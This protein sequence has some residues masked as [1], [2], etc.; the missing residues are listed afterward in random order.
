MPDVDAPPSDSAGA[1]DAEKAQERVGH[2]LNA[3][4][5]L[6]SLLGVGGMGAVYTARHRN[7]SRAAVK[8]L[9]AEYARDP[10]VRDRFLR[11]GKIA[12]RVDHPARVPVTDDDVSD[13]GEPF[14]V[15]D[16]LEGLTLGQMR[17]RNDGKVA[18][19][20]VL[21][22]F[23]TVLDLLGKCH[24]LGIVH[25]DI[26]PANIFVT[27]NGDI[28]VLDF[29]VARMHDPGSGVEATR[30]GTAIGTPSYMA[31]EQ[32][33]G[34]GSQ[35]DGRSDVWSVG[36]C[37]YASL[38]GQ[39]LNVAR[40]EAESFV[41]A[42]TQAAPS[43]ANLAPDLPVEVVAFVDRA[44]AFERG[45]RF[46]DAPSMR[47]DLLGLLS[48]LRA[49]QLVATA[50]KKA[51]GVR[52]R[53]NETIDT[54]EE[55]SDK[56]K[57]AVH[58]KLS[59][60]WKQLGVCLADVR[61]YG[62]THPQSRR[63]MQVGY[64][65]VAEML[66]AYP[67]SLRWDVGPGAF[68][69][70]GK[71]VWAPD[72]MPFDRIPYQLFGDGVRHIQIKEGLTEDELHD[73][74]AI[75]LRDLGDGVAAA[76]TE[77]DSVTALW[78]RRFEHVAY[79]AID[80]FA[81]GTGDS[82]QTQAFKRQVD[83]LAGS[84]AALAQLDRDMD[85][86]SLEERA[87][88]KNLVAQLRESG[89]AAATLAL[90]PLTK[91][92][93]GAQL[94]LSEDKWRERF[95]D[96]FVEAYV[97]ARA[98][99]D[100]ALL[101]APLREWTTDQ[102]AL[103]GHRAIFEMFE[104]LADKLAQRE[105]TARSAIARVM[106]PGPHIAAILRD[107]EKEGRD[108]TRAAKEIEPSIVQG[109]SK[110]LELLGDGSMLGVACGC[111]DSFRSEAL[112]DVL[113]AYIRRW[114]MGNEKELAGVI[115]SAG[116]DLGLLLVKLLG[117][118]STPEA[119]EALDRA[120]ANPH[121]QVRIEALAR[122][123]ADK[124]EHVRSEIEKMLANP[125]A[126]VRTEALKLIAAR[127]LRAAGPALVFRAQAPTFHDMPAEERRQWL[128]A[129]VSLNPR[130]GEALCAGLLAHHT[131]IQKESVEVT[132]ALAA[133]ILTAMSSDEALAAAQEGAKKRWWNSQAVREAS[134]RALKAIT[135]RRA[136]AAP[137]GDP[138]P[139]KRKAD[140]P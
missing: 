28:K 56:E 117:E 104:A 138:P 124:E 119:A 4:W 132:R 68:L 130:R 5:T 133:E 23:D 75:F 39:R 26:K 89:E 55:L 24:A 11:E 32:A 27:K 72:R 90:D 34:L 63:T 36:A 118:I 45:K 65:Q 106:L 10:Q 59:G 79:L 128:K 123:P 6:E 86:V 131:L 121:L 33:L 110:A 87:M 54:G 62:W 93:L 30:A 85:D 46:Q 96:G 100:L 38:T 21:R 140:T 2:A 88:Q 40:T 14:L 43:I 78:D 73:L 115:Q 125:A 91:A 47:S 13:S 18:L 49:G 116:V 58:E 48:A 113:L 61:Q 137:G 53:G 98:R 31:P 25:R 60:V 129:I 126:S 20:E 83:T 103:N 41:M 12:N 44:L 70:D 105:P 136:A 99:G 101:E 22:I 109:I 94:N 92:T 107:L 3:K 52:A 51:G 1:A 81:E 102:L 29:G 74:V 19:E 16:L 66:T 76:V 97:D 108:Q 69:F 17:A 82:A 67:Q 50:P 8:L 9:H 95:V 134:E 77:G 135:E 37:M 80:S 120:C 7:G 112:R 42:A 71:P 15:M 127:E 111:Y 35:V 114:V 57:Q 64:Q 139:S 122:M 84:L